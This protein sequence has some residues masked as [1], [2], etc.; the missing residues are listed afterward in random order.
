[1]MKTMMFESMTTLRVEDET[2][3]EETEGF[4]NADWLDLVKIQLLIAVMNSKNTMT[5]L[6][7]VAMKKIVE[8]L[9]CRVTVEIIDEQD[10][11]VRVKMKMMKTMQTGYLQA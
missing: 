8:T 9:E 5:D 7:E 1:M 11:E 6:V 4:A 2:I 3:V 10:C